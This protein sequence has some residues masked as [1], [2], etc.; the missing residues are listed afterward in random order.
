MARRCLLVFATVG[1][2]GLLIARASTCHSQYGV[3]FRRGEHSYLLLGMADRVL[4][5]APISTLN[6]LYVLPH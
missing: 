2:V 5:K 6:E 3:P 4:H 1:A